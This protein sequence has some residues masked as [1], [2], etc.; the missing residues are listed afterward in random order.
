M[1]TRSP[2]PSHN[3]KIREARNLSCRGI[4]PPRFRNGSFNIFLCVTKWLGEHLHGPSCP[5][6]IS[7]MLTLNL[8]FFAPWSSVEKKKIPKNHPSGGLTCRT[9]PLNCSVSITEFSW[10]PAQTF[11]GGRGGGN[12]GSFVPRNS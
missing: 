9:L 2:I 7:S 12:L 4:G 3:K 6:Q 8:L 5:V 1:L 10:Q 11:E